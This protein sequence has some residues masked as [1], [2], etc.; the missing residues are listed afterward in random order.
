[1]Q[2]THTSAE[3]TT[4]P[5]GGEITTHALSSCFSSTQKSSHTKAKGL[6]VYVSDLCV[7]LSCVQAQ[8]WCDDGTYLLANQQLEKVHSKEGAQ[9]ALSD[10]EKFQEGAPVL[11]NAGPDLLFMEYEVVL[12]PQLQVNINFSLSADYIALCKKYL[13][14]IRRKIYLFVC[15]RH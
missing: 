13:C 3:P 14:T 7:C 4:T 6:F 10:L 11:L 1:M 8:K 9:A 12:T 5:R 2:D 15:L